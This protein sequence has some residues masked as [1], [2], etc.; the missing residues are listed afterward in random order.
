M[1]G[2]GGKG[3]VVLEGIRISRL[4]RL[5]AREYEHAL[6]PLGLTLPQLEVLA[7]LAL[8]GPLKPAAVANALAVERSTIS[9]NLAAMQDRGWVLLEASPAGRTVSVALTDEGSRTL[10]SARAAWADAQTA[11]ADLIGAQS[12][13]TLDSW[14]DAL[15]DA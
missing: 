8:R 2:G 1:P 12:A 7:V 4:H 10:G 11:I 6:R 5:V 3:P 9:R 15:A 14:L 13:A